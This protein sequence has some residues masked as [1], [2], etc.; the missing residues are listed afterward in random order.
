MSKKPDSS[1]II[2]ALALTAAGAIAAY[3][4]FKT[5]KS[6]KELEDIYFDFGN[7]D[8]QETPVNCLRVILI[9]AEPASD[10]PKHPAQSSFVAGNTRGLTGVAV[11]QFQLVTNFEDLIG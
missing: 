1:V 3:T 9:G 4:F 10:C 7:D 8:A 6:V 2:T 5:Y 11:G